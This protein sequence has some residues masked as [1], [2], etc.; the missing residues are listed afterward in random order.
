MALIEDQ[1][2]PT[3]IEDVNIA[4]FTPTPD[5]NQVASQFAEF[6]GAPSATPA[7]PP[8]GITP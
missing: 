3:T 1:A 4:A 2:L 7:L 6:Y 8:G 5:I